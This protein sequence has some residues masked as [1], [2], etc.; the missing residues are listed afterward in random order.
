MVLRSYVPLLQH[1]KRYNMKNITTQQYQAAKQKAFTLQN[2]NEHICME[3]SNLSCLRYQGRFFVLTPDPMNEPNI[4]LKHE[5]QILNGREVFP[6]G[7]V[8]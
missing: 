4:R 3:E 5:G 1:L 2:D 8:I 7:T 6:G